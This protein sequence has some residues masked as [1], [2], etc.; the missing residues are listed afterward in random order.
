MHTTDVTLSD[1]TEIRVRRL[2]LFE[3]DDNVE[4][5]VPPP[6]FVVVKFANGEEYKQAYDLSTPQSKPDVPLSDCKENTQDW[7]QWREHMRY[8]A[9]IVH[10]Q[11][12]YDAY[13]AY[14]EAVADYIRQTCILGDIDPDDIISDDWPLIHQAA[15]CPQVAMEDIEAAL[16]SVFRGD[17]R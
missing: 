12:R 15:L 5:N 17:V 6:Y 8:E 11:E 3:L 9:G 1:G 4:R 14:C 13:V 7:F 2:G 10:E 16:A